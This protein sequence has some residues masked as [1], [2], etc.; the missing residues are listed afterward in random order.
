MSGSSTPA[1]SSGPTLKN[2]RSAEYVPGQVIVGYAA[3]VTRTGRRAVL[4]TQ[5]MTAVQSLGRQ[6]LLVD[7][8]AGT[9]VDEAVDALEDEPGVAYAE[10][11]FVY[12]TSAIPNDT[13]FGQLW[14]LNQV[15]DKDIDA[16][17]AWDTTTGS[18][19]IVVAVIDSGVTFNHPDLAPNMWV[20]PSD[21]PGGGDQDHNGKVDDVRGWD[22][23]QND[24]APFDPSDH[25]THVAGTIGAQGNN[26][27]GI[28]GVNWDV[29]IMALRAGDALGSL[30]SSAIVSAIQY[31]CAKKARVV[32][33][34]FG[35]SNFSTATQAAINSPA[36]ANTLFVFAAGNGGQDGVGD[37]NDTAPTYPCNYPTAR[38]ICV[39]ATDQND[40]IAGFS[41]FGDTNVDL[42]APGVGIYSAMPSFSSL[43]F[44]DF[45]NVPTLF[46][47]RWVGTG[48]WG[49]ENFSF[50]TLPNF[51]ASDTPLGNYTAN[52]DTSLR[53][54]SGTSLAGRTGC[55]LDYIFNLDTE[56]DFDFFRI[57]AATSGSGPWFDMTGGW[58]GATGPTTWFPDT[59]DFDVFEGFN[60]FLRLRLT[61]D[62]AVHQNG[63]RVEDLNLRCLTAP[64]PA[65]EY[66]NLNGTSMASPHVA[67]AAA[68]LLARNPAMP[69]SKV[70][71]L[72]LST[73]DP[74]AGL[75]G[76]VVTA[77]RLN[78][79]TAMPL[80]DL[81]KP[82]TALKSAPKSKTKSK[83]ATFKF[84]SSEAGSTFKCKLDKGAWTAC[85]SPKVYKKLKKGS[86][87]F[88]VAAVDSFGNTDA[89]PSKKT[90]KVTA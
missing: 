20:N 69:P 70:R 49:Q 40:T 41:N 5:G 2:T 46:S 74:V 90:W 38:I 17:E 66:Q 7:L 48:L 3:G 27:L 64:P 53:S 60:T 33:G 73:V 37:D 26:S 16:P 45:E 51:S 58:S 14:G 65:G 28:T 47:T 36:C 89:T 63:V 57:E 25:G 42:A 4:R 23:V 31:A 39:A 61:T 1:P 76:K 12:H 72:L 50:H 43:R 52:S 34:S 29:S 71:S 24:N 77:G 79:A 32:N 22:F 86:H 75:A 68:L 87:T 59:A 83:T 44:D 13:N 19:K 85:K 55:V 18:S 81:T 62:S 84:T 67:G 78:V 10:P 15:S 9:S 80:I 6:A 21:P 82:N 8:P 30:S 35:G 54:L 88:Q 56:L 11:N